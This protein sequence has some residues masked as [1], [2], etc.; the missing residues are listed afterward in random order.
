MKDSLD[1]NVFGENSYSKITK[2]I[3]EA[4]LSCSDEPGEFLS[5]TEKDELIKKSKTD[6][7]ALKKFEKNKNSKYRVN[8]L[9]SPLMSAE[10]FLNSNESKDIPSLEKT[11]F[12]EKIK[13]ATADID[14]AK[15]TE[16]TKN[17]VDQV[18]DIVEELTKYL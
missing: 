3:F 17:E 15:S 4:F 14:K 12:L 7:E 16:I 1:K 8:T 6:P 9:S 10:I 5:S 18:V 2:R 11:K 13:K